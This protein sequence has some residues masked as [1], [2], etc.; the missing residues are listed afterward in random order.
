MMVGTKGYKFR[1]YPTKSQEEILRKTIGCCRYVYNYVLAL[2]R[3]TWKN[4]GKSVGYGAA[5]KVLTALKKSPEMEWLGEVSSVALQQANRNVDTSFSRFFKKESRYPRLKKKRN[6]GSARFVGEGFRLK[7][8]SLHVAKVDMPIKIKWSQE[9]PSE[10]SSCTVRLTPAGE[11][12]VSFTCEAD[13]AHL[14]KVNKQIGIDLGIESFVTLSNGTKIKQPDSI[15]K[16]RRKLARAQRSQDRKKTKSKNREKARVKVARVHQ[17]IANI[18]ND[19][20]HK[21]SSSIVRENQVI[22]IEDLSV[23]S[24]MQKGTRKLSR[25]IGEQGWRDF[26]TM[27]EYKAEWRGRELIVI[28][29]FAPS[30]QTC[31]A[32]GKINKLSLDKRKFKCECGVTYDRDVNAAQNILAAG[33]AVSACG[34]GVRLP[35]TRKRSVSKQEISLEMAG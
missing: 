25:L 22:A 12:Y 10:P 28:D 7:G 24:M 20:L 23:A 32:C 16:F 11:W 26:R 3:D 27:L 33:M 2:R 18:R 6:G 14:P 13:I 4:E 21:L 15:R 8:D 9:L 1:I 30:S 5:S 34:T 29:R 35:N 31:N 17:R 19:F